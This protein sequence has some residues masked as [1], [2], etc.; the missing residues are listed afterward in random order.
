M[1]AKLILRT[2]LAMLLLGGLLFL[3]AGTYD[4][5]GAWAFLA[6]LGTIGLGG[7]SWL[8]ATDPELFKE[9]MKPMFQRGQKGW[10][11]KLMGAILALWLSWF[12]VMGLDPRYG[13]S[14][15]PLSLQVVGFLLLVLMMV[16][17]VYVLRENRFAAPVVRVQ[18]ERGHRV[19]S[20]GPYAFVR[21]PMYASMLFYGLGVPLLLGALSGLIVAA[22]LI[23]LIAIRA[24]FEERTLAAELPGYAAYAERVRYR[25][26]PLVW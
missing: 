17:V 26:V 1:I 10:D 18:T 3:S 23:V 14:S 19:V 25:L 9:R 21:H 16:I 7:G 4:W 22:A 15:V 24:V 20:T 13:W 12:V 11:K 8:A 5:P 2:I 6:R